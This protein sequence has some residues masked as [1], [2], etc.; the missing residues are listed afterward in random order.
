MERFVRRL[1]SALFLETG[2]R[3]S[4]QD[5][6]R[7]NKILRQ[8]LTDDDF[9]TLQA[10]ETHGNITVDQAEQGTQRIGGLMAELL[11]GRHE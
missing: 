2:L 3:A 5:R 10:T 7:L 6:A 11:G 1:P 4:G 8:G 9:P